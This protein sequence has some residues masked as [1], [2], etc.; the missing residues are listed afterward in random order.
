MEEELMVRAEE[1]VFLLPDRDKKIFVPKTYR[2]VLL[3][4]YT[5]L[6]YIIYDL[7]TGIAYEHQKQYLLSAKYGKEASKAMLELIRYGAKELMLVS[8][9]RTPEMDSVR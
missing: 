7:E 9:E 5:S 3:Y 1:V 2:N 6:S 4:P 8:K